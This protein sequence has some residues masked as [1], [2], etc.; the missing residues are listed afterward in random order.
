M[1]K[2]EPVP[3]G[4]LRA[5]KHLPGIT[6]TGSKAGGWQTVAATRL[7]NSENGERLKFSN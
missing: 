6:R 7:G 5:P 1:A 4:E 2:E 3:G